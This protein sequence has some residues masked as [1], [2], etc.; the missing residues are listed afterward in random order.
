MVSEAFQLINP[1]L[2]RA[3]S[4]SKGKRKETAKQRLTLL[5]PVTATTADAS[6]QTH[7]EPDPVAGWLA[8][9]STSA[10]RDMIRAIRA[11]AEQMAAPMRAD[12][13]RLK[14]VEQ[15]ALKFAAKREALRLGVLEEFLESLESMDTSPPALRR[16]NLL[17]MRASTYRQEQAAAMKKARITSGARQALR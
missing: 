6:P 14:T 10:H 16:R 8:L 9:Y 17:K 7:A 2:I 13:E 12:R 1:P 11:M 3:E 4:R 15:D 5:K